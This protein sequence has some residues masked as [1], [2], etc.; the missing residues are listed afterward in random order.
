MRYIIIAEGE[1]PFMTEWYTKENNYIKGMI[2]I[3]TLN[4]TYTKNGRAWYDMEQDHL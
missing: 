3:D 2:V 1:A 4:G